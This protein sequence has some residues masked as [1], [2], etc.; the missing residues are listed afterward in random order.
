MLGFNLVGLIS[1]NGNQN[2]DNNINRNNDNNNNNQQVITRDGN[3]FFLTNERTKYFVKR[4]SFRKKRPRDKRNGLFGEM[5]K[6]IVLKT[7]D[8]KDN[9]Y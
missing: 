1:N 7:N 2:N 8:K 6:N 5:K 3:S 9:K 4:V